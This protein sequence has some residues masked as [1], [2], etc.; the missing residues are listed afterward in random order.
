MQEAASESEDNTTELKQH[1]KQN[2]LSRAV[3]T[4]S[5]SDDDTHSYEGDQSPEKVMIDSP[6]CSCSQSDWSSLECCPHHV[7]G[8]W[9]RFITVSVNGLLRVV[10]LK[11]IDPY[12]KVITHGGK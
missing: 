3:D 8:L 4:F 9:D 2:G 6:T 7:K 10:D 1:K 12:L 11:L 5:F